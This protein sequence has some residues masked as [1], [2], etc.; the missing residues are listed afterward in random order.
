MT[1]L[2][3]PKRLIIVCALMLAWCGLWQDL[4]VQNLLVGFILGVAVTAGSI[5]TPFTG[6][7]R[8]GPLVRLGWLV[9]T[10]LVK[11][12]VEVA[13]E[14]LTPTDYTDEAI[15]AVTLP[16][17]A[18]GHRLFLTVAITLTPGTAVVD[19]DPRTGTLYLHLLHNERRE[20]TV[21][22]VERMAAL[23]CEALPAK[24]MGVAS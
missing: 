24:S 21:A 8:P 1:A 23:A 7:V 6:G 14:I 16:P 9:F 10:D 3:R 12:T 4:S 2:V 20:D 5:A 17:E 22:H 19:A 18:G 15:V 13:R 11:S